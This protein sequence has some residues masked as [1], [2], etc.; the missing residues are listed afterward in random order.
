MVGCRGRPIT[1]A[2]FTAMDNVIPSLTW[3]MLPARQLTSLA[4]CV[5]GSP[6]RD[7]RGAAGGEQWR[8]RL[9][10]V[11]RNAAGAAPWGL[12][13]SREMW[14]RHHVICAIKPRPISMLALAVGR[15]AV[16]IAQNIR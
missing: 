15:R 2:I 9:R 7:E 12:L 6:Q 10:A 13:A 8:G 11:A 16:C 4:S 14:P 3:V 1:A 5:S